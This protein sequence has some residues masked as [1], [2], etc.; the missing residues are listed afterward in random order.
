MKR[1][2]DVIILIILIILIL[3]SLLVLIF[4]KR[5]PDAPPPHVNSYHEG[6]R[7]EVKESHIN[8]QEPT[9]TLYNHYT[10]TL[11]S[12]PMEEYVVG[13][14]AAEMPSAFEM[15]ALKAQAVAARTLAARKLRSKGGSGCT[16]HKGADVCSQFNHCQAWIPESQQ[17]KNW[18][19]KY[20]ENRKRIQQAVQETRGYI[21]TYEGKP[22]E[23]FFYSTSNG[24]TEDVAEVFSASLP[25]Y[26]VVE[27]PGEEDAPRYRET[28]SFTYDEFIRIFRSKYPNSDLS[29]AN[30]ERQIE[31]L[32]WTDSGRVRDLRVGNTRIKATEFRSLYGLN[33]T[34]F[35]FRFDQGKV[36][37]DTTGYGH[38]VGMSQIGANAMA[39]EGK[40]YRDILKHYYTG[41]EIQILP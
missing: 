11:E 29:A 8:Y 39:R 33:S 1:W 13:V 23:V 14:V 9:I 17:R 30:L 28:F 37:I 38:G 32:S 7:I 12:M 3:P 20:E 6:D 18:G 41:V 5:S 25:Y 27:S 36:Y 2:I 22:I 16:K 21:I 19:D 40:D 35:T 15:E 24:K 26:K 10:K 34:D 31:I 4:S